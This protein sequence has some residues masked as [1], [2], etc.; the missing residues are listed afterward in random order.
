MT[1]EANRVAVHVS[2]RFAASPERAFDAWL[3]PARAGRFLFA[4]ESGA[5]VRAEID[6]RVGGAFAFVDR[7]QGRDIEHVGE[8]LAIERPRRLVFSFAV[9]QYSPERTRVT[10]EIAPH[11][12]GCALTLTHE[13]VLPDYA[14]RT[15]EGWTG[16]LDRLAEVLDAA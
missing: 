5:M 8:Y 13:G 4:T 1:D 15:G 10:V 6:P 12:T 11:G 9:P 2:R 7:R 14:S 3:E 16:I